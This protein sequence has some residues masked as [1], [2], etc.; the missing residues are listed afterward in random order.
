VRV[1]ALLVALS[2]CTQQASSPAP[3]DGA[4]APGGVADAEEPAGADSPEAEA[5]E[6][7]E[8]DTVTPVDT[9][10]LVSLGGGTTEIVYALGLGDA[11]VATDAS[12]HHPP[13]ASEKAT[14]GYYRRIGAEGVLSSNPTAVLASD[15]SGPPTALTQIEE[16]GVRVEPIPE[17]IDRE[18]AVARIRKVGALLGHPDR[19]EALARKV[20]GELDAV[21]AALEGVDRPKVLFIYARGGGTLMVGGTGTAAES[22]VELAGGALAAPDHEGYRPLTAEAVIAAEPDVV[23]LTEGG[24]ATLGGVDG[25]VAT[26]GISATPAGQARRVVAMED[27]LML[28]FG[29]RLG[30]A[31]RTLATELHP[32]AKLPAPSAAAPA[33]PA[34]SEAG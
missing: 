25:V 30:E 32:D 11:V 4:A 3:S 10:R 5:A 2:A 1:L 24:L 13:A 15:G 28:G 12:S 20:E 16:A 18:T 14:L 17:A 33:E 22:L 8:A 23:L 19:A 34:G 7:D 21:S 29:P 9:S 27:L 31:V 26:P 6:A